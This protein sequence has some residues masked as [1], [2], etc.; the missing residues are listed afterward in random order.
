MVDRSGPVF[1]RKWMVNTTAEEIS[2][3]LLAPLRRRGVGANIQYRRPEL[4]DVVIQEIVGGDSAS[5]QTSRVG[6]A[7]P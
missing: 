1:D 5:L 3:A 2:A 4:V 7:S 6:R